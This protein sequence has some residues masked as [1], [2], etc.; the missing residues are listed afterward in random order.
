MADSPQPDV[1]AIDLLRIS[2][3]GSVDDG[4]STLIG[5]LLYETNAVFEDQL[6]EVKRA[7][8]RQGDNN[9]NLALLTDGLRAEREQGITIDVAYR[10]FSTPHRRFIVADTPGHVQY[11]RNMVTGMSTA[12]VAVILLDAARGLTEQTRR[13]ALLTALLRVPHLIVC[14]NKMDLVSFEEK[15]F[16]QIEGEFRALSHRIGRDDPEIIPLSSL[17]GDNVTTNSPKMPWYDGLP[18]LGALEAAPRVTSRAKGPARFPIQRVERAGV[19]ARDLSRTY[20]G[21]VAGGVLRSGDPVV[22]LPI[23]LTTWLRAIKTFDG[24]LAT[25]SPPLSVGVLLED[26]IDVARGDM[27]CDPSQPPAV[28]QKIEALVCWFTATPLRPNARYALKHTTRNTRA[29]V[30]T[31]HYRLDVSTLEHDEGAQTLVMNDIGRVTL[32]TATPLCYD[33]YAENR[34]TGSFILIDEVSHETAA[35]GMIV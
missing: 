28:G 15:A 30:T 25:A 18:L 1:E 14:V 29:I 34:T 24:S 10:Y 21:S 32:Q 6:A 31:L 27:L 26:E 8:R 22:L 35:A 9:L 13:H 23:G 20:A 19:G 12:D 16:R 5:R 4:K 11:T 3:A 7:S 17:H 2:T 33:P